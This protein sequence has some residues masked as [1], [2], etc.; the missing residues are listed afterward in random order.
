VFPGMGEGLAEW[1]LTAAD[2]EQMMPRDYAD[3]AAML[4]R[5][6]PAQLLGFAPAAGSRP[7]R[8]RFL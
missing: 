4:E 6:S 7:R 1:A 2:G 8:P 3:T 5:F